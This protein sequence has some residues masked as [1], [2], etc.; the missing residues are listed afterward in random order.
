MTAIHFKAENGSFEQGDDDKN[1]AGPSQKKSL[2]RYIVTPAGHG[3]SARGG[4][5]KN[6]FVAYVE[7][8]AEGREPLLY[9][10]MGWLTVLCSLTVND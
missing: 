8:D 5:V 4:L 6:A 3:A 1:T 9:S 2:L 7:L 10:L